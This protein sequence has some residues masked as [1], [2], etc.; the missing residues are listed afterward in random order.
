[1]SLWQKVRSLAPRQSLCS[2]TTEP[3][4]IT[5]VVLGIEITLNKGPNRCRQCTEQ[6]LNKHSVLCPMCAEPIL[7]GSSVSGHY[8]KTPKQPYVHTRCTGTAMFLIGT[9]GE[10]EVVPEV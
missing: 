1:M 4:P 8:F 3:Y 9:W 7:P 10:G 2:H 6:Y 5:V